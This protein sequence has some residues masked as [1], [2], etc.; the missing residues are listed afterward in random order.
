VHNTASGV[1][2]TSCLVEDRIENGREI[3]GRAVDDLQDL[4]G[5]G[6]LLQALAQR[7]LGRFLRGDVARG[8]DNSI[9]P[10]SIVPEPDAMLPRPMPCAVGVAVTILG[11]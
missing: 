1:A 11:F 8:P 3:A 9:N 2:E 6:L 7:L 5:R 4:G 10:A